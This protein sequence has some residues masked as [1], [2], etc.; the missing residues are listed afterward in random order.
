MFAVA[1]FLL[2]LFNIVLS[3]Q[4][5]FDPYTYTQNSCTGSYRWT[6]WFDTND[7][8]LRQGDVEITNHIQQLFPG[9]MCT[10]PIAIEVS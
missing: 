6:T 8:D 7:P 5:V 3:Q 4:S 9:F 1:V 10:S 2:A